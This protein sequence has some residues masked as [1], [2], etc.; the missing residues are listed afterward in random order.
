MKQKSL[1][2]AELSFNVLI[3]ISIIGA[4]IYAFTMPPY[5]P[6]FLLMFVSFP[7]QIIILYLNII[8]GIK[9][10]RVKSRNEKFDFLMDK[11]H[12]LFW[13]N[14]FLVIFA[15]IFTIIAIQI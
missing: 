10:F 4:Y 12:V 11:T 2:V 6:L 3:L 5:W 8:F 13:E 15:I 14:I 9:L 1:M 7:F